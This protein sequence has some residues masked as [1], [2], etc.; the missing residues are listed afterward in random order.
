[1][2]TPERSLVGNACAKERD[3][4][5]KTNSTAIS[6]G[7]GPFFM[8]I[9]PCRAGWPQRAVAAVSRVLPELTSSHFEQHLHRTAVGKRV[10]GFFGLVQAE[11]A[12]HHWLGQNLL[13]FHPT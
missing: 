7:N 8:G 9:P 10:E 3:T 4:R 6:K 12:T 1:M 11:P 5:P 13:V 2:M